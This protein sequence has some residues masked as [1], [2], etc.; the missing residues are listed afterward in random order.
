MLSPLCAPVPLINP[1][2]HAWLTCVSRQRMSW[3]IEY[4]WEYSYVP[5]RSSFTA[6]TRDRRHKNCNERFLFAMFD[7]TRDTCKS[8]VHQRVLHVVLIKLNRYV[9][10]R[11]TCL[12]TILVFTPTSFEKRY[13]TEKINDINNNRI[14]YILLRSLYVILL[15][16]VVMYAVVFHSH[17][18]IFVWLK[19]R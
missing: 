18:N 7:G 8:C 10:H 1:I 14:I 12:W 2:K 19:R 11:Q 17:L 6:N 5:H 16:Y 4:H 13:S 15:L 3:K 9:S